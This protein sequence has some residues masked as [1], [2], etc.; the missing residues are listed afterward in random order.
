MEG[1]TLIEVL[2]SIVL[3]SIVL[4][5]AGTFLTTSYEN[6]KISTNNFSTLQLSKSLL[7]ETKKLSFTDLERKIGNKEEIDI[8]STLAGNEDL[9]SSKYKAFLE[10]SRHP[11]PTLS[12]RLLV[13]KVTV[14][15]AVDSEKSVTEGYVRK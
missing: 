3:L 6:T 5:I 2:V 13:L 9:D 7:N 8:K 11:S 10:V 1:F 15:A 14:T 4:T 12:N